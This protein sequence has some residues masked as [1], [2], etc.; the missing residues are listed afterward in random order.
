MKVHADQ[1]Q[2]LRK[3]CLERTRQDLRAD[4]SRIEGLNRH[5]NGVQRGFASGFEKYM[6]MLFNVCMMHR[7]TRMALSD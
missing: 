2:H 5:W 4:G 3:G 6:D 1:M 7:P